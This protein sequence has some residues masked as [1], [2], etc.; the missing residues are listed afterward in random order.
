MATL[1]E[2]SDGMAM[3][4]GAPMPEICYA[5]MR[6]GDQFGSDHQFQNVALA[7]ADGDEGKIFLIQLVKDGYEWW[8]AT[9]CTSRTGRQSSHAFGN[10]R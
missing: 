8:G 1:D 3:V 7:W 9:S 2:V 4:N 10:G 6:G 5:P